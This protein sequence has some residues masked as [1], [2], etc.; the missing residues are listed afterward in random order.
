MKAEF[1]QEHKD[2][3]LNEIELEDLVFYAESIEGENGLYKI[4]GTAVVDGEK[5]NEFT[6]VFQ[7]EEMPEA[8]TVDDIMNLD[9]EWY[10][11]EFIF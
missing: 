2:K 8:E 11:Y 4:T 9:W 10:D 6:V 7:T 5:Y 3:K 1:T